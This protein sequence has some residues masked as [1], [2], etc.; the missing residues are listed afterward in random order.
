MGE[1]THESTG[2]VD[3]NYFDTL[4]SEPL[5]ARSAKISSI[6]QR[7]TE[8][9]RTIGRFPEEFDCFRDIDEGSIGEGKYRREHINLKVDLVE[10]VLVTF[11]GNISCNLSSMVKLA[12]TEIQL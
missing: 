3:S 12:A 11:R 7:N 9:N 1:E 10:F 8:F 5:S 2:L 6:T 4:S